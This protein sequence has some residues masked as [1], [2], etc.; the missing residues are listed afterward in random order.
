[1]GKPPYSCHRGR[2]IEHILYRPAAKAARYRWRLLPSGQQARA[3]AVPFRI[4]RKRGMTIHPA[5][6]KGDPIRPQVT[7]LDYVNSQRTALGNPYCGAVQRPAIAEQDDVAD[8]PFD[9]QP[10][11]KFRPLLRTAAKIDASRE[12]PECPVAPIKINPANRVAALGESPTEA[13][14]KSRRHPL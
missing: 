5:F 11:E 9:D 1:M 14:E 10:I 7:L 4:P 3:F 13:L 2:C 12:P 6:L 8:R